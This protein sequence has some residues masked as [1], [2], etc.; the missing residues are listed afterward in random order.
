[1]GDNTPTNP[2]A[3]IVGERMCFMEMA[4]PP[5]NHLV[6]TTDLNIASVIEAGGE[7]VQA[8]PDPLSRHRVVFEAERTPGLVAIM[9]G[10]AEGTLAI[11]EEEVDAAR[12]RLRALAELAKQA[13]SR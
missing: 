9:R 7:K 11:T 2:T 4:G 5:R 13:G 3:H 10:W 1:M 6:Q 8:T 12:R